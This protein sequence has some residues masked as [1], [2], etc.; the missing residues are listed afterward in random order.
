M[1]GGNV[2]QKWWD[3]AVLS[4]GGIAFLTE[5]LR[6]FQF[7][8][9]ADAN[10]PALPL[11]PAMNDYDFEAMPLIETGDSAVAQNRTAVDVSMS[12]EKT[13]DP[14]KLHGS[15]IKQAA[16][17]VILKEQYSANPDVAL[18]NENLRKRATERFEII[19]E[20][21]HYFTT[22]RNILNRELAKIG[23]EITKGKYKLKPLSPDSK[24]EDIDLL[25]E[26][27]LGACDLTER[28]TH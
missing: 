28:I 18:S 1:I 7:S 17:M 26:K 6:R 24:I 23:W 5:L 8:C 10:S 22:D 12:V 11:F 19:W 4:T 20:R 3:I 9:Y 27:L 2:Q 13:I 15:P 21:K 25:I 14:P 16:G